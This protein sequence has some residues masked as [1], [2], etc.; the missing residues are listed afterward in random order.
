LRVKVQYSDVWQRGNTR[1]VQP[2]FRAI[3]DYT[4]LVR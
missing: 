3:V 1:T 2:E 4:L